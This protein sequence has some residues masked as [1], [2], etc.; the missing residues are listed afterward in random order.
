MKAAPFLLNEDASGRILKRLSA[1]AKQFDEDWLQRTL[2]QHPEILPAGEIEFVYSPLVSLGREISTKAGPIDN[3]FISHQGYLT[4]VETKLWRNPEAK[5]EVVAQA[6]DYA[7]ALTRWTFDDLDN[8]VRQFFTRDGVPYKGLVEFVESKF[9][10]VE[11]EKDFFVET[12]EKNLRLGRF[13]VLIV[14]D[15][16][17]EGAVDIAAYVNKHPGFALTMALVEL[18][19]HHF[20]GEKPWPL[21][22]VPRIVTES[23]IVERSVVEVTVNQGE[24]AKI[25]VRQEEARHKNGR[26]PGVLTED[27]FWN[28]VKEKAGNRFGAA[29]KLVDSFRDREGVE[30]DPRQSSVVVRFITES[31]GRP[32]SIFFINTDAK[33]G[34]W[35]G[36][37]ENQL[38]SAELPPEWAKAYRENIRQVL[39][40]PKSRKEFQRAVDAI[41][42]DDFKREVDKFLAELGQNGSREG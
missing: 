18:R 13:L 15:R 2:H 33:I 37:I 5:R 42:F 27:A 11:G 34:I 28:L 6:M 16:I 1:E 40:M 41:D 17:R 19:C 38:R 22:V 39:K 26:R 10:P 21:F 20:E 3:L 36:T 23:E 24:P 4:L 29:R 30:I 8:A 9:G 12:V 32:I 14:G 31:S 35:P 7:N 25:E